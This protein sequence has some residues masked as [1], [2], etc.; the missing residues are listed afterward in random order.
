MGGAEM[1][2]HGNSIGKH[3]K[4]IWQQ[5]EVS[6]DIHSKAKYV[7]IPSCVGLGVTLPLRRKKN[8]PRY[9]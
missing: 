4:E 3:R 2:T 9:H 5:A 8:T 1:A 6:M 7:T